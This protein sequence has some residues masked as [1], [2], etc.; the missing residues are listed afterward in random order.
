MKKIIFLALF[1]ILFFASYSYAG[2]NC[3]THDRG[4][5]I[6]WFGEK[7]YLEF[8]KIRSLTSDFRVLVYADTE[9]KVL[10]SGLPSANQRVNVPKGV[11]EVGL[12]ISSGQG[13]VCYSRGN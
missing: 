11:K 5:K 7:G 10:F 6:V 3:I 1:C 9:S 12:K 13:E 8:T 2:F 4:V